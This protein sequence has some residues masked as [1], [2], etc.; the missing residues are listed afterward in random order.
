VRFA[1][2]H[3]GTTEQLHGAVG[4]VSVARDSRSLGARRPERLASSGMAG[5][6]KPR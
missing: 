6:P 5:L 4:S 2:H 3:R 1:N